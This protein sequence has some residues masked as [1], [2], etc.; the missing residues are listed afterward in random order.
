MLGAGEDGETEANVG[1]TWA[2]SMLAALAASIGR[3]RWWVMAL[4]AFLVR[5]GIVIVLLPLISLPSAGALATAFAPAVEA[6]ALSR[7]SLGAALAGAALVGLVV[8]FVAAAAYTGA[9][10]DDILAHEA[11]ASPELDL[12]FPEVA[13]S[14]WRSLGI[15]LAAH[16]PTVL[17]LAYGVIRI[18]IV[19]YQELLSPGDPTIPIAVRVLLRAPDAVIIA[20]VVWLIGEAVGGLA[21][22]RAAEGETAGRSIRG[23]LRD[24]VRRRGAATFVVTDLVVAAV[25]LLLVLVVGR[26]AEHVR[27]YLLDGASD[28]NLAAALLLLVSTWVLAL[29]VLGAA[30]AWRSTA[31]TIEAAP[32]RASTSAAVSTSDEAPATGQA[33]AG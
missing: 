3:P 5:G 14:A 22:R 30:L 8:A 17:A 31:W 12:R 29:A 16:V 1:S 6:L 20:A 18:V 2:G 21:A 11:E 23:A 24:L 26:A 32:R 28:V 4:A 33:A 15:R 19:T 7:Q 13:P 9:W 27:A 25:A 10:L